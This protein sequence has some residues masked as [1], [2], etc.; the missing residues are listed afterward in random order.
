LRN[1]ASNNF[2]LLVTTESEDADR[3]MLIL[4][5]TLEHHASKFT[6]LFS[7][8][9]D[10]YTFK[11]RGNVVQNNN[12]SAQYERIKISLHSFYRCIFCMCAEYAEDYKPPFYEYV[13][14]DP[15]FEDMRKVVC[16]EQI[17][18]VVPNRWSSDLVSFALL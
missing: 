12:E 14:N 6:H 10:V 8:I 18:P 11:V 16:V 2:F 13:P 15:S 3:L 7:S 17:R 1:C 5:V 4:C 9:Y